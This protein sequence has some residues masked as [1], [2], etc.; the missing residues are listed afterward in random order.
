MTDLLQLKDRLLDRGDELLSALPLPTRTKHMA[1]RG[2]HRFGAKGS[3]HVILKGPRAGRCINYESGEHGSLL[4]LIQWTRG[5]TVKDAIE[6]ASGWLGLTDVQ[7][8]RVSEEDR[9]RRDAERKKAKEKAAAEEAKEK[10]EERAKAFRLWQDAR[11]IEGTH[12]EAYLRAR[13]IRCALPKTLRFAPSLDYWRPL[14]NPPPGGSPVESLGKFP[15]LLAAIQRADDRFMGVRRTYLDPL[16]PVK[17]DVP[18]KKKVKGASF[19]GATRL[20]PFDP[21]EGRVLGLCEG[22]ENGLSVIDATGGR[23]HLA[24]GASQAFPVWAVGDCGN[25]EAAELP[26]GVEE[27]IFLGDGDEPDLAHKIVFDVEP[28]TDAGR[29]LAKAVETRRRQ[30]YRVRVAV[31]AVTIGP[32]PDFKILKTDWNDVWRGA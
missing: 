15:V 27:A 18:A 1:G 20:L 26:D 8:D 14:E 12:A 6:W 31:P 3:L 23:L 19:G 2:E 5:G 30:G 25:F 7:R 17:A 24:D 22:A 21:D 4:D 29:K 10:E 32:A 16:L 13:G 11:P 9:R 28:A